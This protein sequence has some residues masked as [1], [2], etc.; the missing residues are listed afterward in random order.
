MTVRENLQTAS[1]RRDRWSYVT[2]LVWPVR[3]RLGPHAR[4]AVREFGLEDDLDRRPDELP[5]GRRR[6]VAI[7]RAVA[8]GPSVLMLDEPAA[9]LDDGET[10]ELGRLV[11]RLAREWGMGVLVVEH[12]VELVLGTC[13]RV[14]VLDSGRHLATGTPE[15]IRADPAVVAAYLGEPAPTPG[16]APW[17]PGSG[18]GGAGRAARG[19]HG[20]CARRPD[21]RAGRAGGRASPVEPPVEPAGGRC[22][23][24]PGRERRVVAAAR[25]ARPARRVRR[26]RRGPRPRPL[27]RGG[28]G[29][30]PDRPQ[31]CGED[32]DAADPRR[33][34][35]AARRGGVVGG[36]G[37]HRAARAALPPR[38]ARGSRSCPRS[39]R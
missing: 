7:A 12:D 3:P 19:G 29:R 26:P 15:E 33:R 14:C 25:R 36:P 39:A 11:G 35:P 8:A 32:H 37:R 24:G 6:L 27:R 4:A 21:G 22:V 10:A 5:F 34:A 1:D 9:G 28:R 13:D 23:P 2:D 38:A 30:R 31:R 17:G 16:P 18:R 20:T